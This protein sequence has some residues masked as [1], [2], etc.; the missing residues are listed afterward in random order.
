MA[1]P[2]PGET[3][4]FERTDA[5]RLHVVAVELAALAQN[6]LNY[7]GDR[8]EVSRYHRMQELSAELLALL[9]DESA[10]DFRQALLVERGHATPKV[11]VRAALFEDDRVLLVQE[12]RDGRWTLPG[13]WADAMDAPSEAAAR[14]FME[15][16]GIAV[17]IAI[18]AAVH[19]GTRHNAHSTGATGTP[20]HIYKLLFV[21]DRIDDA[22]PVA[23]L[24]GETTDVGF[25]ALD[26]L[27][28]LST[29]RTTAAQLAMLLRHHHDRGAPTEFD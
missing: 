26:D 4:G 20:W 18:L 24:D 21:A 25:F 10:E 27:P 6:G 1:V 17:R 3:G 15:E 29:G 8:Y 9:S 12:A 16:A 2:G 22:P 7:A 5:Q 11:D 19:D 23:G 13:G 14:E 28:D